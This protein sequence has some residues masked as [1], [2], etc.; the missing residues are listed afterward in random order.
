A[1]ILIVWM[2]ATY[3]WWCAIVGVVR[4]GFSSGFL[5]DFYFYLF[6]EK[7]NI[8]AGGGGGYNYGACVGV[9]VGNRQRFALVPMMRD[10]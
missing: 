3:R 5:A 10:E 7:I 2:R 9:G 1:I 6:I 4:D 8:S